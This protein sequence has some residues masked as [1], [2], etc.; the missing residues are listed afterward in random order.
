MITKAIAVV[1]VCEGFFRGG[2]VEREGGDVRLARA[3]DALCLRS[4]KIERTTE[5]V[6][7]T[8]VC[9]FRSLNR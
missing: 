1:H 3:R 2:I 5:P 6:V 4:H 8:A 9:A 7:P